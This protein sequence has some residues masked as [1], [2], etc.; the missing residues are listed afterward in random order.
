[1]IERH[2]KKS[3]EKYLF[4]RKAIILYGARQTGKTTLMEQILE[5]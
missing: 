4:K 2:L 1:M 3:I 5:R